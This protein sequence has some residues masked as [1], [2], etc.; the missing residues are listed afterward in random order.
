MNLDLPMK[1]IKNKLY[2]ILKIVDEKEFNNVIKKYN[3]LSKQNT[4]FINVIYEKN[5]NFS[6]EEYVEKSDRNYKKQKEDTK[7]IALYLPQFHTIP[8]NDEW[9]GNGF[10]EW[11]N[12]TKAQPQFLGHYQPHLPGELG[13]YDLSNKDIFYKQIE[14]A[15]KYGIYGF[16]FHYYWFSGRRLL[17]KPIFNYLNDKNLDFPFMLCWANE[18]WSRR[19]DGSES[20]ILMPQ[21]FEEKDYIKFI[22]DIMPFFKDERYIKIDNCPILII[23]RPHYISKEAMND[24]IKLWKDHA[25]QNGF[26]GLYL[27]N[28]RTGGFNAHPSEWG[29]DATAEFP[30]NEIAPVTQKNLNILNPN[31]K[32]RIYNLA[33]TIEKTESMPPADYPLY[34]TVFPSW[35]NTARKKNQATIFYNSSPELYKKWLYNCIIET[36]EKHPP[37]SQII[38]I[39]AWNEWAEGAHLEPDR[40]YGF[41][42]LEATLDALEESRDNTYRYG[43]EDHYDPEDIEEKTYDTLEKKERKVRIKNPYLYLLLKSKGNLKQFLVNKRDYDSLKGSELFDGSYYLKTYPQIHKSGMDPL[44]HY[45]LF[46]YKEGKLPS[47]SFDGNHY[48]NIYNDVKNRNLNPLAHYVIHG[49]KEGRIFKSN[50]EAYKFAK[51][52]PKTINNILSALNSEKISIIC[53]INEFEDSENCIKSILKNTKINHE[54][55]LIDDSNDSE[56]ENLLNKFESIENLR[57]IHNPKKLGFF[58]SVNNVIKKSKGDVVLIKSNVI[59]TGHWLQ[60]MVVAAYY[61]KKIGTVTP[62]SNHDKFLSDLTTQNIIHQIKPDEIASLVENASEHLKPEITYPNGIC[63]FIKRE[64]ISSIG[65]LHEGIKDPQKVKES[66]YLKISEMMETFKKREVKSKENHKKLQKQLKA[67]K[68]ELD[69]K[70]RQVAE[71]QTT[72]GWVRYKTKNISYRLKMRFKDK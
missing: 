17:E 11:T 71:L 21:N 64:S 65:L 50:S 66:F 59:V 60:K 24:A 52:S 10:T 14:L 45:C 44:L 27:I 68:R 56:I 63:I 55:I 30:P 9:W 34:K 20:D 12:V 47:L 41:A 58:K 62:L 67:K 13:F 72:E 57:I 3:Q 49:K 25:K 19:W 4:D 16:C 70:K 6:S 54:L 43:L 32:G 37:K 42:Y 23:Y 53:Y 1:F 28:T 38:F 7:L 2:N 31:F 69:A 35:D 46:G 5:P 18:P 8:E 15:R 26:D 39:N 51:Y 29:L 48:L 36:K 61:N 40:K 22:E 33:K